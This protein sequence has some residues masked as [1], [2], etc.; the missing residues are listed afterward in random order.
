MEKRGKE[1]ERKRYLG[2]I[3][4][5]RDASSFGWSFTTATP[6]CSLN[7]SLERHGME[8]V[9]ENGG[10]GRRQGKEE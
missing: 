5:L 8:T 3:V 7:Y 6:K 1:R 4:D 9:P 2:R 10:A